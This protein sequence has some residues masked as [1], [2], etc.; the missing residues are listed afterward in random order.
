MV[1]TTINSQGERR[2]EGRFFG[3]DTVTRQVYTTQIAPGLVF[4][5]CVPLGQSPDHPNTDGIS[6]ILDLNAPPEKLSMVQQSFRQFL[7]G[8]SVSS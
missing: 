1:Q 7:L 2:Y 5:D 6:C 8:G 3:A 4:V